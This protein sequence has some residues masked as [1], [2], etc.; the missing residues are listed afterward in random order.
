MA[1]CGVLVLV[2]VFE[3]PVAVIDGASVFGCENVASSSPSPKTCCSGLLRLSSIATSARLSGDAEV[4]IAEER[5]DAKMSRSA[6]MVLK[7]W[8][9]G[10]CA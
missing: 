7:C 4:W 3:I 2:I 8:F 10:T 9:C 6:R 1:T 5:S